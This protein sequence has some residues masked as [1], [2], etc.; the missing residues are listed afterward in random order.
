MLFDYFRSYWTYAPASRRAGSESSEDEPDAAVSEQDVDLAAP[1]A[2]PPTPTTST[3]PAASKRGRP[4]KRLT[5]SKR[6]VTTAPGNKLL[7]RKPLTPTTWSA[8]KKERRHKS[9]LN[10]RAREA[11]SAKVLGRAATYWVVLRNGKKYRS[12]GGTR[13][14]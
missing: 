12:L 14:E 8:I 6:I 10:R 3:R 2:P 9:Y 7:S 4:A 11:D 1:S 5:S 13:Q